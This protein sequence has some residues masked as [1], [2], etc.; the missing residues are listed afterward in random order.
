MLKFANLNQLFLEIASL[1]APLGV[2]SKLLATISQLVQKSACAALI[3][4][5]GPF[6]AGATL[7]VPILKQLTASVSGVVATILSAIIS[8]LNFV[9][10]LVACILDFVVPL[11]LA[12]PALAAK[13]CNTISGLVI[14][15]TL[16]VII[17]LTALQALTSLLVSW[18]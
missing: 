14:G 16:P 15:L 3:Q 13:L 12:A 8:L 6:V 9:L 18:I 7:L 2:S 5:L 17:V 4:V 11:L 1:A 10:M